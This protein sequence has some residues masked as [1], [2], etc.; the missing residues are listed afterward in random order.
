M[1]IFDFVHF[2]IGQPSVPQIPSIDL[3][4]GAAA[5]AAGS[6]QASAAQNLVELVSG[7][8]QAPASLSSASGVVAQVTQ[9]EDISQIAVAD[10]SSGSTSTIQ[11]ID[12]E[13]GALANDN[14]DAVLV[15]ANYASVQNA[16][17]S[18]ASGEGAIAAEGSSLN[19]VQSKKH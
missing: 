15:G 5:A 7:N 13:N 10:L 8:A 1:L 18:D 16:A 12:V 3:E 6:G 19:N 11:A 4:L 14:L 9:G 17:N 2:L